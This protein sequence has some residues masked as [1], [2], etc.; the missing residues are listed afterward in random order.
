MTLSEIK[1]AITEG[2]RVFHQ[3]ANYEVIRDNIGQYL[4][5]CRSNDY[6]IGLTWRDGE[7]MNGEENEFFIGG[8]Q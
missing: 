1:T 3:S 2:K 4:I 8:K 5:R 6:C 7:T